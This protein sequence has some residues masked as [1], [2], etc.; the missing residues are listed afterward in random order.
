MKTT[1]MLYCVLI[2]LA[3]FSAPVSADIIGDANDDGRITTA[4]S[5][6]ALRM[7]VGSIAPDLESADVSGDGRISSLDAL[8]I[9]AMA[10]KAQVYANAPKTVS[11]AFNAT[12]DIENVDGLDSGQFD[13]SFNSSVVNVTAV[14]DGN[15]DGT[16][17]PVSGWSF[18][19]A[20]T[21]RVLFNCPDADAVS[22]SG[23]L[24]TIH[25]EITGSA[26]DKSVLGIS[27]GGLFDLDTYGAGIPATWTDCEVTIGVPVTVNAPKTVSGAFNATIDIENVDGLDSGQFDLSFNSSVVNVTAVYDGNIDGTTVPVSGWSFIDA[28]TIRV[29]FNCPDADA[30]SGS[31]SLATVNFEITGSAGDK[32]VLDISDGELAD[33]DTYGE[34][35]PATWTDCV[36]TVTGTV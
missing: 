5:V 12:I 6:L 15:I 16:T 7:A 35:I 13:L 20:D 36:V 32:G 17:V 11:G 27:E 24:A 28:D 21:I 19:D 25:F 18:I 22:G 10:Q 14:Y 23:S 29:L 34:G 33:L 31:G 26:G 8:M 9:L 4:D 3:V 30:V 2:A 1:Y